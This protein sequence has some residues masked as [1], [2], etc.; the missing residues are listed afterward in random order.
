LKTKK[1]RKGES[2]EEKKKREISIQTN[3]HSLSVNN[4]EKQ[5]LLG[6]QGEGTL[7]LAKTKLVSDIKMIF[8]I[9]HTL[10][11]F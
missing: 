10:L 3:P 7:T 11:L 1:K 9:L 2:R 6:I 8:S 4:L 5:H